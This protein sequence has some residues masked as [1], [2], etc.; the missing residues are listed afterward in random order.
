MELMVEKILLLVMQKLGFK[1][2]MRG[3]KEEEKEERKME[4]KRGRKQYSAYLSITQYVTCMQASNTSDSETKS[5]EL[6]ALSCFLL[7]PGLCLLKSKPLFFGDL[8]R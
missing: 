5:G 6:I 2:C 4:S 3:L 7:G 1:V 8:A